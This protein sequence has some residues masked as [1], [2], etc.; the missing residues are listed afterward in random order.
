M[1]KFLAF[2]VLLSNLSIAQFGYSDFEDGT[3]NNW[4][5]S[6][7]TTTG[8][9]IVPNG[10][11][12]D[13]HLEKLCDGSN[14]AVGE[15]VVKNILDFNGDYFCGDPQ[16]INCIAGFDIYFKNENPFDLHLRMGMQGAN[17]TKIVSSTPQIYN[18][19]QGSDWYFAEFFTDYQNYTIVEG[20]GTIEET[21]TDIVEVRLIHNENISFDGAI[22]TGTLKLDYIGLVILLNTENQLAQ[23][24]TIYPNPVGDILTITSQAQIDQYRIYDVTGSLISEGKLENSPG[25]IDVSNLNSGMYF[26]ELNSENRSATRKFIK[27]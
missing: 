22:V 23:Q 13:H 4:T 5:N 8:L 15:M 19:P 11:N 3:F 26:I 10:Q 6:D 1:K 18:Y 9:S 14:S 7:G 21:I 16:G 17:G 24:I 27:K 25:Q 20:T 12:S 2:V